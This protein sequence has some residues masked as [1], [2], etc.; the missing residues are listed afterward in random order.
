M[1]QTP[2]A[3]LATFEGESDMQEVFHLV[4]R[5]NWIAV[6]L[7]QGLWVGYLDNSNGT[8]PP[9][10]AGAHS[11]GVPIDQFT[12]WTSGATVGPD[13]CARLVYEPAQ[14]SDPIMLFTTEC[15]PPAGAAFF[16]LGQIRES[17]QLP[18]AAAHVLFG[19]PRSSRARKRRRG[20]LML[21]HC[22]G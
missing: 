13:N 15:Q 1:E 21:W 11:P 18:F 8:L 22:P 19:M 12:P 9:V 6:G 17:P 3:R 20:V 14:P 7:S 2:G 16:G 4:H 5:A 10:S